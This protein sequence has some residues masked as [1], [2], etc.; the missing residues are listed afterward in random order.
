[1]VLILSLK[2]KDQIEAIIEQLGEDQDKSSIKSNK[3]S[4]SSS[5]E[6]GTENDEA[7]AG[8]GLRWSK[9]PLVF[10][11][12]LFYHVIY[13]KLRKKYLFSKLGKFTQ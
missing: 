5:S 2:V 6:H 1:M 10:G 8:N 4:S 3:S 12:W 11:C 7:D 13:L 9:C